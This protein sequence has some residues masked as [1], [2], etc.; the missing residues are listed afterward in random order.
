MVIK[1]SIIKNE[2]AKIGEEL[3][4]VSIFRSPSW[5]RRIILPYFVPHDSRHF[6]NVEEIANGLAPYFNVNKYDFERTLIGC[7]AWLHDIGMSVWALYLN[8][9]G[10]HVKDLL[11]DIKKDKL[12]DF[13]DHL[14]ENGLFFKGC[15]DES[16][17]SNISSCNVENLGIMYVSGECIKKS[18]YYRLKLSRFI[19]A[20]HPWISEAYVK[21]ELPKDL[22]LIRE[23]GDKVRYFSSLVGEICKIHDNKVELKDRVYTFEGYEVNTTAYGALLRIADALDFKKNRVEHL[24]DDNIRDDIINDNLFYD[25]KYWVFKY[26]VDDVIVG[27]NRVEIRIGDV[28]EPRLLGFLIFEVGGNFAEDYET[29]NQ[30]K[31]LPN[32]VMIH[33]GKEL[34]LNKYISEL[35]IAYS[36]L[37]ELKDDERLKLYHNELISIGIN[38]EQVNTMFNLINDANL[39][40]LINLPLDALALALALNKNAEGIANLINEDLPTNIRNHLGELLNS[41]Q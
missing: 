9:L 12:S 25:L 41:S 23:L 7:S 16:N 14:R 37:K 40:G 1:W 27:S 34:I 32:M 36:K 2:C 11:K 5:D 21:H 31:R 10:I 26:A 24:F 38:E 33:N 35:R 20:Y 13:K 28:D 3:S 18:S 4:P 6:R 15:I 30:Y 22:V 19:R 17:C 29:V 8:N 39:K